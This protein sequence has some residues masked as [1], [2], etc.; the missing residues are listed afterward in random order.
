MPKIKQ[1][2]IRRTKPNHQKRANTI[3]VQKKPAVLAQTMRIKNT[4]NARHLNGIPKKATR[5]SINP[6]N[7]PAVKISNMEAI[8][9]LTDFIDLLL[10][11]L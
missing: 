6:I 7:N 2:I 9:L 4:Q 11:F 8:I 3:A 5:R 10:P 1:E